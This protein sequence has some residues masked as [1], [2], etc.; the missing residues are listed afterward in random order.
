MKPFHLLTLAG[1]GLLLTGHSPAPAQ[2]TINGFYRHAYAANAGWIDFRPTAVDGVRVT[3]TFLSGY[4]YAANFGWIDFGRGAPANGHTYSNASATDYG[5][6]LSLEGHL[7]GYAYAANI[8]WIAFEQEKGLPR[9][10]L[11]NGLV[12]GHAYA[13]NLGWIS[14]A[15]NLSILATASIH[16]PDADE[17]GMPDG[18]ESYYWGSRNVANAGSDSDGDGSPDAAEYLAGTNPRDPLS[19]FRIIAQSWNAD[20][21]RATLTFNT[22][23]TRFYALEYNEGF[24]SS[25]RDSTLGFFAPDPGPLT[26][27]ELQ[28]SPARQRFY[29][30]IVRLPLP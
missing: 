29:R 24:S 11:R 7:S 5:V 4:A 17:D 26:V 28:F 2:S 21:T 20:F 10:N 19:H 27:R 12:S 22:V 9:I 23:P 18:W 3:D 15:T 16:R 13:A 6:N 14:L 1:S 25:W 8:G 30:A